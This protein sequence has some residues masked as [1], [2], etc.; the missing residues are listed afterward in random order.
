MM[1][2]IWL[3]VHPEFK[4]NGVGYTAGD[5]WEI[6]YSLIKEGE[7]F[8]IPIGEFF[9]DWMSTSGDL[10]VR[11]SGST[12]HPKTI[13][14]KK[15]W[16]INSAKATGNFFDLSAGDKALLCL[17]CSSIAGKMMLVR[18]MLLGL[19]LDYVEP[20]SSPLFTIQ[21]NYAFA[22]MVPMQAQNSLDRLSLIKKLIVGGAP[23][24]ASLKEQ[25]KHSKSC[26]FETYGMTETVSH[27]A[28][29]DLQQK[30]DYFQ[31]LPNIAISQ[32]DRNC[33]VLDAP[34][35]SRSEVVTND[36]VEIIDEKR[37]QWLGRY[38]SVINSGGVKLIPEQIE[39]KLDP[40]ID[41]RFFVAGLD[42]QTLG[43][44]LI[45]LVEDGNCDANELLTG[46]QRLKGIHKYEIPK[47]IFC[48]DSFIE[49][50]SGKI[51]RDKT[52]SLIA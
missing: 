34:H 31:V 12:G 39:R 10:K 14:I 46:I 17:P 20:S 4:L 35:L 51:Q 9:L 8:E 43:Q 5:L 27:V 50:E 23:I 29:R 16:M 11:T 18:A 37:F 22:A 2:P 40:V 28:I 33:L 15:E 13:A 21:K 26:V 36:L 6:G 52:L 45:L 48:V 38:D 19:H 3:E 7:P 24:A 32:D 1:N 47:D 25:L 44:R 30:E 42:D 41:A 49:T